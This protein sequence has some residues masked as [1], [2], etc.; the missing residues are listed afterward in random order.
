MAGDR[1]DDALSADDAHIL[2]LESDRVMGHTLKLNVLSPG[3]PVDLEQLRDAVSARLPHQ[4]RARMRVDSSGAVA[5]WVPVE[6]FEI[7]AHVRR[8]PVPAG[9]TTADQWQVVSRLMSEHLDRDRPLWSIDVVGPLADGSEAIAV[10]M[11]HAMVDGIAGVRFLQSILWDAPPPAQVDRSSETG[12]RAGTAQRPAAQATHQGGLFRQARRVPGAMFR[13]LGHPGGRSPFD[14]PITGE[15]ELA[16]TALPLAQIKAIGSS[17][18]AGATINDVLLAVLAGALRE[19]LTAQQTR[20][21]RRFGDHLHAQVPVSLRRAGAGDALGNRDSFFNVGLPLGE[22]D[23]V[24]RLDRVRAQTAHRKEA[25][26]AQELYDVVHALGRFQHLGPAVQRVVDSPREFGV[27]VSNVPGPRQPVSVLGQPLRHLFSSSEPAPH[28]ALRVAAIS[29]VGEAL[30]G[31]DSRP[32]AQLGIGLCTDPGAMT[33]LPDL[34][35][36]IERSYDELLTATR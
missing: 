20:G 15:R 34:A 24:V 30:S 10:R 25:G 14:R 16:F 11:H 17:R 1:E 26:D 6:A 19:W 35:T 21:G 27:S 33:G 36:S 31:E 5:R 4:P 8:S 12:G 18:P 2:A 23:P 28:H 22:P 7:R 32:E 13:E 3:P 9:G 29:C